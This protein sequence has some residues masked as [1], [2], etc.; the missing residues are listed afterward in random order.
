MSINDSCASRVFSSPNS[1]WSCVFDSTNSLRI[2]VICS[3]RLT[4][5]ASR[6]AL[7][8]LAMICGGALDNDFMR[9][10]SVLIL[11]VT[12]S[13]RSDGAKSSHARVEAFGRV[14][15]CGIERRECQHADA[16]EKQK[17]TIPTFIHMRHRHWPCT[18]RPC[19]LLWCGRSL[20]RGSAL[21]S[22]LN[23]LLSGC[24][25]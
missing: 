1:L 16:N 22:L 6:P 24:G 10:S 11:C 17:R 3:S 23:I 14:D 25:R 21:S 12:A 2:F 18:L 9:S 4:I 7:E 15:A 8:T 13:V 19:G 5:A 20:N